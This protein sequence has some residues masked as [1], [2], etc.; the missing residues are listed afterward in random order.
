MY[1]FYGWLHT[2]R[3]PLLGGVIGVAVIAAI[4]TAVVWNNNV[5]ET[6][7][8][9]AL[10]KVPT[11]LDQASP[12]D[13]AS[14]K[15]LLDICRDYPGTSAATAAQLLAANQLFMGAKYAEA[16]E[17]FS[18]FLA[19]HSSS[20]L[21]PQAQ[22]GVAASLEAQNK[23]PEAIQQYKKINALYSTSYNIV[24]P[25]KL[26]L[27]R[28][29]EADNKPDQAVSFYMELLRFNDPS[30]PWVLEASERL[31]LLLAK[32][33]ELTPSQMR[34]AA[35]PTPAMAPSDA[36]LQLIAPPSSPAPAP[37]PATNSAPAGNP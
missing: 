14:T 21:A 30:D 28:L 23:I 27:G 33:P 37:Q 18:K 24:I 35:P 4:V 7:A 9:Q 10:L 5:K 1:D 25:V 8:D 12:G 6:A 3:K 31:R 29:S 32:H 34:S 15:A 17:A 16:Q 20:S 26:T 36:D 19:G 13:P 22:V 11:L 2:N